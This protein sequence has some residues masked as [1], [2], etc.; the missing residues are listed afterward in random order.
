VTL[1]LVLFVFGCRWV[2][3]S[4]GAS[5]EPKPVDLKAIEAGAVLPD[6]H[7]SIGPHLAMLEAAAEE[8]GYVIYPI[9]SL[10]ETGSLPKHDFEV[11]SSLRGSRLL[12][13]AREGEV[14]FSML[15]KMHVH[16]GATG[17]VLGN[18]EAVLTTDSRNRL[19][20]RMGV[21]S[22]KELP[23]LEI[24]RRPSMMWGSLMA[25]GG[26]VLALL[27]LWGTLSTFDD[28]NSRSVGDRSDYL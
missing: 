27:G 1:G 5:S 28:G 7:I 4:W 24:G 21:S 10:G 26:I 11:A 13:K 14:S 20:N 18:A 15:Q 16:D 3:A 25:V 22:V 2:W 9:A 12:V 17:L 23:V 8:Q 6:A 19:K